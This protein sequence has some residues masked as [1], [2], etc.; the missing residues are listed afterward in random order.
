[1]NK[2]EIADAREKATG[3]R[4]SGGAMVAKIAFGVLFLISAVTTDW[5]NDPDTALN[6]LG[7]ML[8][9]VVLGIALI[10]WGLIP[11]LT[12]K[13]KREAAEK[14]AEAE[15]QAAEYRRLNEPKLC[16]AC[17]ATTK[18]VTCEYCGTPLK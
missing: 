10:L 7:P 4:Q 1:M 9:S 14:R 6:P 8:I 17:G 5:K 2:K 3:M 16:P 12:A 13:K 11:W 18:G 15:R